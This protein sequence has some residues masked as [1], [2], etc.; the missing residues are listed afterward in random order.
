MGRHA[1]FTKFW[2]ALLALR[3][4]SSAMRLLNDEGVSVP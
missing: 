1:G 3:P 4:L 2:T